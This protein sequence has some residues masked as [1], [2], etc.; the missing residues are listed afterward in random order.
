MG[1]PI[2]EER[3]KVRHYHVDSNGHLKPSFLFM[4]LQETAG[5]HHTA[6][7]DSLLKL[8][9]Q[10][11]G[12]VLLQAIYEF[13]SL[14]RYG[15]HLLIRTWISEIGTIKAKREYEIILNEEKIIGKAQK[16]WAFIDVHS[17]RPTALPDSI[18]EKWDVVPKTLFEK[19]PRPQ[20]LKEYEQSAKICTRKSDLDING[21][22]NNLRYLEWLNESMPEEFSDKGIIKLNA[23]FLKESVYPEILIAKS[24]I[25]GQNKVLF[26]IEKEQNGESCFVAE[27]NFE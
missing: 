26:S 27:V 3:F 22:V 17:K 7:Q 23:R 20:M 14:P 24:K 13:E 12:W 5:E 6:V 2:Y 16:L 25:I 4:I 15:Q 10:G 19:V 8:Y 18:R 11:Y 9:H 1:V 21:H